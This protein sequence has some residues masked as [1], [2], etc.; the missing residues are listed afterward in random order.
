M[1]FVKQFVPKRI[2]PGEIE[3]VDAREDNEEA[4]NQAD[5]VDCVGG[6][7][8]S[9]E[10]EG[11]DKNGGGEEDVVNRVNAFGLLVYRLV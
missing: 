7:E 5:G 10:N 8:A 1:V 2:L 9:E 6:V 4:T 3:Q 11:S